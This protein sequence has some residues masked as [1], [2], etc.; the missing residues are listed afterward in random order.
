MPETIKKTFKIDLC[1]KKPNPNVMIL[2]DTTVVVEVS[3]TAKK[4]PAPIVLDRLIDKAGM[5]TALKYQQVI[6]E[7]VNKLQ[8]KF[9]EMIKKRNANGAKK[10]ADETTMSVRNACKALQSAVNVAVEAQIKRDYRDD[11]NLLEAQVKVGLSISFKVIGI[12]KDVAVLAVSMGA[13]PTA[14]LSLAKNIYELSTVIYNEA[15]DEK[16]VRKDLLNGI[17]KYCTEKQRRVIAEEKA[18]KSNKA[19]LELALK[20]VYKTFK[21]Q[22]EKVEVTRKRYRNKVTAMRQDL[23]KL[24]KKTD[25][26]EKAMRAAKNLKDGV[27]LGAKVMQMK[28]SVK[29]TY[30]S[31]STAERFADD[32]AMLL[33]EA[34]VK[35]D[36]R[37]FSQRM[38]S[39]D[40][41]SDFA[42]LANELR[43]AAQNIAE[44]VKELS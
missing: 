6:Q 24:S 19:K 16:A 12:G 31:L 44:M 23:E 37:T 27:K 34:G 1:P 18:A 17:G 35:V 39:L 10:L 29:T 15:K 21:P 20:D 14:W 8:A 4:K 32:M 36:E 26:L 25:D 2:G 3:V 22:S 43:T 5:P 40:G 41:V 33:T 7:E 9:L 11:Q 13:D 28:G 38:S 30:L 42:S